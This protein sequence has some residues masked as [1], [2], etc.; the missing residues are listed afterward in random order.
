MTKSVVAANR[1]A[2]GVGLDAGPVGDRVE[3]LPPRGEDEEDETGREP[4]ERVALLE[5]PPADELEDDEDEQE[6]RDGSGDGDANGGH[7]WEGS[8][9]G[10]VAR[11]A[12]ATSSASV[13]LRT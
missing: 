6:R 2:T 5:P 9:E 3:A 8:S 4:Q 1:I 7:R 10:R 12:I 11:R 13:T